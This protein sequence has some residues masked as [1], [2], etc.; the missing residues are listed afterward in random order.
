MLLVCKGKP[1]SSAAVW[2]VCLI[3]I[4][5]CMVSDA[6]V[7]HYVCVCLCVCVSIYTANYISLP[8]SLGFLSP[9]PSCGDRVQ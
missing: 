7:V 5:L 2:Q 8:V 3:L 1:L 9:S 6:V 4:H